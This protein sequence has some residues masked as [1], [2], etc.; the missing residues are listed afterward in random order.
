MIFKNV[1]TS[2]RRTSSNCTS[3]SH[4][5]CVFILIWQTLFRRGGN[6]LKPTLRI[7]FSKSS[8]CYNYIQVY[9]L[10]YCLLVFHWAKLHHYHNSKIAA[11]LFTTPLIHKGVALHLFCSG[12]RSSHTRA[13][14]P[15]FYLLLALLAKTASSNSSNGSNSITYTVLNLIKW[16]ITSVFLVS[17]VEKTA[18]RFW[19]Q[20]LILNIRRKYK[21]S[22]KH[23]TGHFSIWKHKVDNNNHHTPVFTWSET[24][25]TEQVILR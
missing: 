22:F 7:L 15:Y 3:V 9:V 11:S 2:K 17:F 16:N 23:P 20:T 13:R 19:M 4:F 12:R 5:C 25:Q 6:K 1:L 8:S 14:T 21:D 24:F 10:R 18:Q